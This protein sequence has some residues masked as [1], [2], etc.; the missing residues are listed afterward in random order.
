MFSTVRGF[1]KISRISKFSRISR[2]GTSLKRRLFQKTP[3]SERRP[4]F[5]KTPLSEPEKVG[6]SQGGGGDK[7]YRAILGRGGGRKRTYRAPPPK[8][9]LETSLPPQKVGLRKMTGREQ[10][11]GK[12]IIGGGCPKPVLGRGFMECFP[13]S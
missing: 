4:L 12:C 10:T 1:S 8:P 6:K 2:K 3:F 5:R 11:R 7:P 9:V 13:L